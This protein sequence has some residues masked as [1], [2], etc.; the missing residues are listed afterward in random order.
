MTKH[1]A[2][3]YKLYWTIWGILLTLT[4]I[5]LVLD[6]AP[7]PRVLF[8]LVMLAAMLTKASLIGIY[9]MHLRFERVAIAWMVCIGLLVNGAIL[10]GLIVPDAFRILEMGS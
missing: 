6:Q 10:Y 7:M 8:V 1:G 2:G 5:M 3:G 4:L 9:F